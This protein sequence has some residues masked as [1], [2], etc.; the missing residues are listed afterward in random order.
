MS[1]KVGLYINGRKFDIDVDDDF[2]AYLTKQIKKDFNAD[3]NNEIKVL[4]Q[5]YIRKNYDLYTQDKKMSDI[6]KECD[7]LS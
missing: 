1:Q 3:G 6:I 7:S 5:A 4:L 2:A